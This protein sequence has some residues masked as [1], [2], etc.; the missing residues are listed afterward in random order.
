MS[1]SYALAGKL[2]SFDEL[3]A[4]V[5]NAFAPG[6]LPAKPKMKLVY[7]DADGDWMLLTKT[8]SWAAFC[9]TARRLLVTDRC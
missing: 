1:I 6:L 3:H 4:A 7:L 8:D 2:R 5:Q 9:A